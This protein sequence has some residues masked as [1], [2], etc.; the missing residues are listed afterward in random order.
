[1]K[2]D[3]IEK[4]VIGLY[5]V[6]VL[7]VCYLIGY[8]VAEEHYKHY[9]IVHHAAFYEADSWGKVTFHWNDDS[10]AQAPFQDTKPWEILN[11]NLFAQKLKENGVK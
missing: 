8:K 6:I 5:C 10:Y 11:E 7:I 4:F 2:L 9:A 1:M 3:K